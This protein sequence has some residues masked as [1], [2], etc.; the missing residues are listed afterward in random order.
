MN[1]IKRLRKL[2]A[3]ATPGPWTTHRVYG[4]HTRDSDLIAE[5]RNALPALL[6][7]IEAIQRQ[8]STLD[9]DGFNGLSRDVEHTLALLN[10]ERA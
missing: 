3:V 6:A 9:G 10:K 5:M 1:T 8:Q 2:E 4:T 7:V